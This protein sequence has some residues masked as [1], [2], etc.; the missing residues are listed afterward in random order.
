[1]FGLL[2]FCLV[3]ISLAFSNTLEPPARRVSDQFPEECSNIRGGEGTV[4][5]LINGFLDDGM[6]SLDNFHIHG[7]RWHTM[8]LVREA[9]R[10]R[11]L[12]GRVSLDAPQPLQEASDYVIGFNLKG[13]HKI[14]AD[15]FFP[16]MREKL[17]SIPKPELSKAF[18]SV[19][20]QLEQDR[21]TVAQL[22]DS[23]V[24]CECVHPT[25][26][27]FSSSSSI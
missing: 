9:G 25:V 14:E 6:S 21:K 24:S 23:I 5:G 1:M 10:L 11:N 17:T 18:A 19:M 26:W 4:Q 8:S 2:N 7:W 13:L 16:W 3:G 15:L 22:G 20:D 12:A 27:V